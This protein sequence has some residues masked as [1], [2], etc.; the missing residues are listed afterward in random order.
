MFR[1][2]RVPAQRPSLW[3]SGIVSATTAILLY[4][5]LYRIA[6]EPD[7]SE[8]LHSLVFGD[9]SD[10]PQSN[11]LNVVLMCLFCWTA[12]Y[13]A[14]KALEADRPPVS[15]DDP[16]RRLVYLRQTGWRA[17]VLCALFALGGLFGLVGA[18]FHWYSGME[19]FAIGAIVVGIFATGIGVCR[20]TWNYFQRKLG[21][22]LL[23]GE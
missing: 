21:T 18:F 1:S 3:L 17:G 23:K 9:I 20:L 2:R 12:T 8:K 13:S 22:D 15:D 10:W 11:L 6:E 4:E 19:F 5:G 7:S 14:A 16:P